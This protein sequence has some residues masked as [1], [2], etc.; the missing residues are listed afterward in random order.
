MNFLVPFIAALLV[1]VGIAAALVATQCFYAH[2]SHDKHVGVQ[3][4]H[5][6][7]VPRI[8]GLALIGGQIA[9]G[10]TLSPDLRTLWL[11][12][13]L[14]SI[15]AFSSGL[16]EDV[17]NRVGVKWR[18]IAT[19]CAG[20]I[21]CFV[22]GYHL[23]YADL[24]GID[25][26][27]SFT[28]FAVP[29]TA[30][31]IAG[32]AN[33]FNIIDGVNGLCLGTAI[34]TFMGLAVI[35]GQYG[36][37]QILMICM[38]SIGAL[39]GIF[40]L[41]FPSGLIF[42]GDGG[43]YLIGMF[44]VVTAM[45]LPLRHP[46]ISPL[47]G[48]LGLCYPIFEMLVSIHRRSVRKGSH[49]GQPD[50]LHLHSLIFRSQAKQLAYKMNAPNLRNPMSAVL[51]WPLPI[52]SVTLMILFHTSST[53]ILIGIVMIVVLYLWA[54]RQVTLLRRSTTRELSYN[55]SEI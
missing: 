21:F 22:T 5:T 17:T 46:E 33:A 44:V 11:M 14:S 25:W 42:L 45:M 10:L 40:L 23:T 12:L 26:L 7:T 43:A 41:N 48:L 52:L 4:L 39:M 38:I 54:Y 15:P 20:L 55:R 1:S 30:I 13:F 37:M 32:V 3:K 27:L 31:V 2:F 6:D 36:D 16:L 53:A 49:P 50:R 28:W 8:G 24:P 9:G 29:L 19:I 35:A 34:I 47:V 51:I 18:L